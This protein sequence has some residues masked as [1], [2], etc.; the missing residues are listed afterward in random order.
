MGERALENRVKKLKE[1]EAQMRAL[2]E[3]AEALKAEIKKDMERKGQE[4]VKAGSFVVR[5]K[6]IISS[7]FDSKAFKAEHEALYNQ[8]ARQISGRRFTVA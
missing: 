5:W 8:Y 3:Q 2:E 1:I 7:K 6:T 4:E